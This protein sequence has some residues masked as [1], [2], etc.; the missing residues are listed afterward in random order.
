MSTIHRSRNLVFGLATVFACTLL[1]PGAVSAQVEVADTAQ[2]D[3]V[4]ALAPVAAP[5][6]A[7]ARSRLVAQR[8]I[9]RPPA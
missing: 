1:A 2:Q 4:A 3:E 8:S 6:V 7:M 5:A 9:T